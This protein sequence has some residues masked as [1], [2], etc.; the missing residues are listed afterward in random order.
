MIRSGSRLAESAARSRER[1]FFALA[2]LEGWDEM[3]LV[4]ML[5]EPSGCD[6][7][8][9]AATLNKK[10]RREV[11]TMAR[12]TPSGKRTTPPGKRTRIGTLDILIVIAGV[13]GI[14]GYNRL[15]IAKLQRSLPNANSQIVGEWKSTRGPEHLVFRPDKTIGVISAPAPAVGNAAQ[16]APQTEGSAAAP[17]SGTASQAP[18]EAA[19]PVEG[20]YK[21]SEA[22][23]VYIQLSNGK[24][25]TTIIEPQN[26][27]R[28]D[29]IDSY[30]DGVTTYERVP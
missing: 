6:R 7:T 3:V 9:I 1:V 18:P 22:G 21:L 10:N 5:T 11:V 17:A 29:L 2:N 15:S 16:A 27:N 26:Q 23:K 20:T 25:Y 19:A 8:K 30:T 24:K 12:P 13:L 28:F 14:I 4:S